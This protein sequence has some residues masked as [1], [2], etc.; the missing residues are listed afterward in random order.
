MSLNKYA[1]LVEIGRRS[2]PTLFNDK[3][4]MQNRMEAYREALNGEEDKQV[5]ANFIEMHN[6]FA[7]TLDLPLLPEGEEEQE[8]VIAIFLDPSVDFSSTQTKLKMFLPFEPEYFSDIG[9]LLEAI[10]SKRIFGVIGIQTKD[11][12]TKNLL[13]EFMERNA[14][15][16]GFEKL[17]DFS[18]IQDFYE[19]IHLTTITTAL[20]DMHEAN[21]KKAKK[22]SPVE[23]FVLLDA[24]DDL[25][26]LMATPTRTLRIAVIDDQQQHAEDMLHILGSWPNIDIEVYVGE[27]IGESAEVL[28]KTMTTR[29][30]FPDIILLDEDLGDFTGTQVAKKIMEG[31]FNGYIISTTGGKKPEYTPHHFPDKGTVGRVQK[32]AEAFIQL[33]NDRIK[34]IA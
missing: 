11:T 15:I 32:T 29:P 6:T 31:T 26:K 24:M 19:P 25:K 4:E 33:I 2:N 20:I 8:K 5:R 27:G 10:A 17:C 18:P 7:F 34:D 21:N 3:A 22:A 16:P 23:T 9:K 14:P 30:P 12:M 28:F 13:Y 1:E